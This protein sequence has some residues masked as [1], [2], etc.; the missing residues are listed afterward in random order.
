MSTRPLTP[1]RPSRTALRWLQIIGQILLLI[2]VWSLA[3]RVATLAHLPISGG[4]LGLL[5]LVA[6]LLSG[7]VKPTLFEQGGELLL[8]NMLLYFI[9]LVVSVVQYTSLFE[10]EGLKLMVA[11]G[12]G[13]VSVLVTT[14]FTVE[15]LCA[16]TRKRQLQRLTAQRGKRP[17]AGPQELA[18]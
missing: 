5:V 1:S 17:V 7:V 10:S 9:P 2:L 6:L 18:Q 14:A 13:F 4:I 8:A 12:V 15:W 11:I 3:D 16:W